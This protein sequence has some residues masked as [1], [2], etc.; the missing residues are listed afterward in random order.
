MIGCE[1]IAAFAHASWMLSSQHLI[2]SQRPITRA[3]SAIRRERTFG[4]AASYAWQ[5]YS[6][7]SHAVAHHCTAGEREAAAYIVFTP[8]VGGVQP[9]TAS[10]SERKQVAGLTKIAGA[11]AVCEFV[12]DCGDTIPRT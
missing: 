4:S 3:T 11:D 8:D 2:C 5:L 12:R 6:V 1:K 7:C 10:R 9:S